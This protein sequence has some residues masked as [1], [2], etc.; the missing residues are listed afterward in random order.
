MPEKPLL[1]PS[2]KAGV[3]VSRKSRMEYVRF[4]AVAVGMLC[5]AVGFADITS[6]A[7]DRLGDDALFLAFAPA[8]ALDAQMT[9]TAEGAITP[10]SLKIPSLGVSAEVE[11]VGAKADG[12][13]GTP[14]NFD[15]VSWWSL[16]AKP[17]GEGSAVFAGHVN[18]ALTKSGVFANLS[19]ISK[20]A[21]VVVEDAEGRSLVYRVTSVEQYPANASTEKLFATSGNKQLVLITCDGAWVPSAKTF[22]TRLVVI[23]Q[24]AF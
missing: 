21:Y 14:Q 4:F 7:V 9:S 19:K 3:M 24:P 17:G 8:A 23:A 13:M 15:H 20:G 11:P 16:G 10:H 1:L 22:D 12:T 6:R 18:N 2:A 5:V